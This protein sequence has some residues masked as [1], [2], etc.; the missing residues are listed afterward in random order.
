MADT[1]SRGGKKRG[2]NNPER[3]EQH[4]T[5]R[6]N[7]PRPESSKP[8]DQGRKPIDQPRDDPSLAPESGDR[9]ATGND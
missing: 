9:K 5:T 3:S 1:Q 7:Q 4:Q 6:A 8:S 2:M